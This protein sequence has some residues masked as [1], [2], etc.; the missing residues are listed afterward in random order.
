MPGAF[1]G[2]LNANEIFASIFNMIISQ[3]VFSDNIVHKYSLVERFRVDGTLYGDTKLFYAPDALQTTKWG[4]DAEATNLLQLHR[5]KAPQCQKVTINIFRQISLTIDNYLTKRAW[6]DEYAFSMFNS[7]MVGMMSTTKEVYENTL[8]N[9]FVGT[10]ESNKGYQLQEA[11]L[12]DYE[13][14]TDL[15]AKARLRA[16]RIAKTLADI[17]VELGDYSR[18][19]NDYANIRAYDEDSFIIVGNSKYMNEITYLDLPTIFHQDGLSAKDKMVL[20][21]SRYFG[22]PVTVGESAVVADGTTIRSLIEQDITLTAG[23]IQHVFA[24]DLI[25]TGVTVA[26]TSAIVY[27]AYTQRDDIICKIIHKNGIPFMSAFEAGTSFFNPKSLTENRYLTF[28]HS[29]LDYLADYPF[30]TLHED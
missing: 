21:P 3:H 4:A 8:F 10:T 14:V 17:F 23:G 11:K 1:T 6:A 15:E 16:Q 26:S 25:P 27:P 12:S 19:W 18:D 24:G 7:V 20:L 13:A 30:I 5:P 22:V 9:T 28:G 29:E 2:T